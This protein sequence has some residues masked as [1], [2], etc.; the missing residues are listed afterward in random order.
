VF[1]QARA[2]E[3]REEARRRTGQAALPVMA[4]AAADWE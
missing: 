2:R 1:V 3:Q 4:L